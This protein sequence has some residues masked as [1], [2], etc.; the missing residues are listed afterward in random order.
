MKASA[1]VGAPHPWSL[2]VGELDATRHRNVSNGSSVS[3]DL[4]ASSREAPI[5]GQDSAT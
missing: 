1:S 4:R 5:I 2:A 3:L